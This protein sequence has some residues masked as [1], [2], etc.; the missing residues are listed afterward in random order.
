MP[1]KYEPALASSTLWTI[2]ALTLSI[3]AVLVVAWSV[4]P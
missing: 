3:I 1:L 4:G 2:A